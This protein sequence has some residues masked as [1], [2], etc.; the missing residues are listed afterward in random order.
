MY[1]VPDNAEGPEHTDKSPCPQE[2]AVQYV[3]EMTKKLK[4]IS[5]EGNC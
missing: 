1:C 3:C 4:M 2:L 5:N